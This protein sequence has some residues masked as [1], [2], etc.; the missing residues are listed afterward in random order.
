M[1]PSSSNPKYHRRDA[2]EERRFNNDSNGER[3]DYKK[4]T[5]EL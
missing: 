1:R 3:R 4:F 2:F 5:T